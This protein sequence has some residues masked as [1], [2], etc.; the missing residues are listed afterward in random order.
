VPQRTLATATTSSAG[1]AKTKKKAPAKKKAAK[2]PKKVAAKKKAA[3]PKKVLSPEAKA[4]L[5]LKLLKAAALSPPSQLPATSWAVMVKDTLGGQT[6]SKVTEA[7]Q[8]VSAKYKSLSPSE[9]EVR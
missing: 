6:G 7:I 3:K 2:K 8:E 4:K 5:R 1:S 9:L